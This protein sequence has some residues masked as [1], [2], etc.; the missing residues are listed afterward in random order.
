L[1]GVAITAVTWGAFHL[2]GGFACAATWSR[3]PTAA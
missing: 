3:V 1:G 2:I